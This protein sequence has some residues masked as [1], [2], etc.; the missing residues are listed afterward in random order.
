VSTVIP[1]GKLPITRRNNSEETDVVDIENLFQDITEPAATAKQPR[2]RKEA[3][4]L[5]RAS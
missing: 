3:Q 4:R 2:K 1:V 5:G